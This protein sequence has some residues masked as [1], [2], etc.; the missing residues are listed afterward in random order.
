MSKLSKRH[1]WE[2]FK[3]HNQEYLLLNHKSK[4]EAVYWLRELDAHLRAN[5]NS[6][7]QHYVV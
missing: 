5:S 7:D 2:W 1:F 4:K 6:L 3:R